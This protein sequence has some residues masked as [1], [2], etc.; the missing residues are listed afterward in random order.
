MR[1]LPSR[2]LALLVLLALPLPALAWDADCRYGADRRASIDTAGASRVEIMARAGDLRVQPAGT[3]TLVASGRACASHE[4]FLDQTLLHVRR[5]GDVVRVHVQVPEEMK[6]IGLLYATLDLTVDVPA[7]LPVDVTDSS[8]DMTLD[9][10][11]VATVRDSSGDIMARRLTGDLTIE[12]SSGDIRVEE[13][14][15]T[16][17]VTDSSGDIEIRGAAAVH[18]PVDSSGD[19]VVARVARDVRIERDSSG[20]IA[21]SGVGGNVEVLADGSG[22]VRVSEVKGTVRLP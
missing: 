2:C 14:T 9:G 19:I 10:V 1:H 16:V 13:S 4:A 7:G 18:I 20:D 8:G 3:A 12:D 15:G 6:G 22:Q 5:D 21:V 17:R 11:R